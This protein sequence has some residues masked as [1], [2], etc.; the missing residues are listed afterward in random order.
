MII[1]YKNGSS[2]GW[3]ELNRECSLLTDNKKIDEH[4][5][6]EAYPKMGQRKNFNEFNK[7]SFDL[8]SFKNIKR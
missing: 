6:A 4:H 1:G 2:E 7:G 5:T 3:H 8:A